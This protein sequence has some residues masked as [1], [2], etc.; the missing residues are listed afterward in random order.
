[1]NDVLKKIAD[2]FG[3]GK[4]TITLGSPGNIIVDIPEPNELFWETIESL[5]QV[6][7]VYDTQIHMGEGQITHPFRK[8]AFIIP[9]YSFDFIELEGAFNELY[10]KCRGE[11]QKVDDISQLLDDIDM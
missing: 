10:Q 5:P 9:G 1:M 4:V 6:F 7:L 3:E 11:S 8:G 2:V